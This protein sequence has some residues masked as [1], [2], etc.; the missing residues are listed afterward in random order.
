MAKNTL[1]TEPVREE[2]ASNSAASAS[3]N[4]NASGKGT[5]K[6]GLF[7]KSKY[8]NKKDLLSM[9]FYGI[10][11]LLSAIFAFYIRIIP[12]DSVFLEN[13]FIRFGENDPWYHW[14]NIDYLL[15][16]YPNFLWFDPATT[17]PFGTGQAFAPLYDVILA[18]VIKALQ[19]ITGNTTEAYAMTISAYWPCVLAGVC[20]IVAYFAAKKIFDSRPIG[21]MSAFLL[22]VAPGQFL[23]RSIIG[24]NDHHVAEVLFSTLVVVFLVMTLLKAKDKVITFEDISKGKFSDL[25]PILPYAV[26][27]G[28]A[29]G[30]YTLIWE[31]ALLFAFIIG[32]FITVQMI[33][34]H[35][36][37]EGT[38][39]IA[40]TGILIFAIDFIVVVV[41][42]QIGEYKSLHMMA[43][44]AGI[45]AMLF[46]AVLSYILEKKNLD[47]IY[48]PASL[49]GLGII[50]AVVGSL[51]SSTVKDALL[52][53][54]GFFTRT[55]GALTIG[56][57]SPYFGDMIGP[58]WF[59]ALIALF[60]I[61]LILSATS[62]IKS[63]RTKIMVFL[64]WSVLFFILVLT[65]G[66][67]L[68]MYS[69]FSVMGFIWLF[70]LPLLAYSAVKNNTME[71]TFL[72]IWTIVLLWALVQ[73]NRFSYYFIVP[74]VILTSWT[75]REIA[76][77]VKVGE[78]VSLFKKNY[79]SEEAR[80][81]KADEPV[82]VSSSKKEK[83]ESKREKVKHAQKDNGNE[84]IVVAAFSMLLIFV[85]ILAPT[86]SL[87]TQ[88]VAGTGGPN[89]AWMD[90]S[91]WL[92]DNTPDPGL[93]WYGK[94][95]RPFQDADGD[96][97]EDSVSG[98]GIE[99]FENQVSTVPFDY[100][101]TSYGVLS[102]WDYGHWL[103]VIGKRTVNANPFQFGVGGRR[104]N[105][106]DE[107]I[108]GASPF[109]VAESEKE[110]T[111]YLI[112]IDPREGKVGARYIVTDIEMASG[113]SKFYAMTAWTLDTE[114]YTMTV[115]MN[116]VNQTI[117]GGERYFNSM[118]VRL[119]LLDA[120]GLEQYRMVY[121]GIPDNQLTSMAQQESIYKQ[122]Y[123]Q[124]ASANISTSNTGYVKIF[125][126]VEG[127]VLTG[128][129]APGEVVE[130]TLTLQ[131]NQN[132]TFNYVQST[133][134][135]ASGNFAFR[136]PYSTTGPINGETNF[137]VKPMG[138]YTISAGS[139]EGTVNV[140]EEDV[141][142]GKTVNVTLR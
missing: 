56:E 1:S 20:V 98:L 101:G 46:M 38:F 41:T 49:A 67:A 109:F 80:K 21:L 30:A 125:E 97:I 70:A 62:Y 3:E 82:N 118:V 91:L 35:L 43:L 119:H 76:S 26:L 136:V 110:A 33:L 22:A 39:F 11:V 99:H 52:G 45:I 15:H 100:P 131:T 60:V 9:A 126:Y 90:A 2:P 32:V 8:E 96:G 71:K 78:A 19:F 108:P 59:T 137:A 130:L 93:D 29:M 16:N 105:V 135:D 65:S 4:K 53:V 107:M 36:K 42:P 83:A 25:K 13:G 34:N 129:A 40:A 134:A 28:I 94:Y 138:N 117:I 122:I 77:G 14:R 17:Y 24:F 55:G 7:D 95:E 73:Q 124:F 113:M 88:Y 69:T 37:G 89:D 12:R 102:W 132:R 31:G 10:A 64:S 141:L 79:L 58:L 51:V 115:T 111:G 116:G 81:K 103:E 74:L 66:R 106:T 123:N 92:R 75:V 54:V 48:F 120:V 114:N 18:T 72:V 27:T 86:Y 121:E 50:V 61:F 6:K 57:A 142:N 128:K 68:N 104:G 112:D 139:S 84:K 133:E 47:K 140:S 5:E 87:T 63:D 44:G 23:S 127:A 85:I